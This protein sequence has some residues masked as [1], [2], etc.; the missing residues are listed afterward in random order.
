MILI[1]VLIFFYFIFRKKSE[2]PLRPVQLNQEISVISV[3]SPNHKPRKKLSRW[4]HTEEIS[5]PPR[6]TER[7]GSCDSL[8]SQKSSDSSGVPVRDTITKAK[9]QLQ[10]I[11]GICLLKKFN[12]SSFVRKS[13][14][15]QFYFIVGGNK[16][17]EKWENVSSAHSDSEIEDNKTKAVFERCEWYKSNENNS[18]SRDSNDNSSHFYVI[19]PGRCLIILNR[20]QTNLRIII[21]Y[22]FFQKRTLSTTKLI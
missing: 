14:F 4:H 8:T 13:I 9:K 12:K 1:F 6:R 7:K 15:L 21:I 20:H 19:P 16:K 17:S 2:L 22:F 18:S 10:A 11:L 3:G 5:E